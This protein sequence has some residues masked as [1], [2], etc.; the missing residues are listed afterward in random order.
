[1]SVD[2]EQRFMKE[3]FDEHQ[4]KMASA[5]PAPSADKPAKPPTPDEVR[6]ALVAA[7]PLDEDG[8]R[9]LA[10]QRADQIR[11]HLTGEGRLIDE[12]VF[13]LDVDVTAS[14]HELVHSQLTIAAA[15]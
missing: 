3:L 9:A 10:S 13:L 6:Q 2:D 14:G 15:P 5:L 4:K 7:M 12:R 1:M 8:L 11:E